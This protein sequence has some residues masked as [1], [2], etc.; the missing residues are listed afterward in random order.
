MKLTS[1]HLVEFDGPYGS[2]FS[3][4]VH[5]LASSLHSQDLDLTQLETQ[6]DVAPYPANVPSISFEYRKREGR[7]TTLSCLE[8][9]MIVNCVCWLEKYSDCLDVAGKVMLSNKKRKVGR[10]KNILGKASEILGIA[11]TTIERVI[12]EAN[13]ISPHEHPQGVKRGRKKIFA[14]EDEAWI[15]AEVRNEIE[16]SLS[17][18]GGGHNYSS[19]L[20]WLQEHHPEKVQLR[21]IS[22]STFRRFLKSNGFS[23]NGE[24]KH[25]VQDSALPAE[26]TEDPGR[27]YSESNDVNTISDRNEHMSMP[28][29]ISLEFPS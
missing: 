22:A 6:L 20:R 25:F 5:G 19:L 18:A 1:T 3:P 9:Q 10:P 15:L 21:H 17:V 29:L 13:G 4:S 2:L 8:K 11:K 12:A 23:F 28:S 14:A 24:K 26:P 7:G 16:R 27:S